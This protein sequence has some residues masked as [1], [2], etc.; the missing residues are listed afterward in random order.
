MLGGFPGHEHS[1]PAGPQVCLRCG[2][3]L[4]DLLS[5]RESALLVEVANWLEREAATKLEIARTPNQNDAYSQAVVLQ[6][7]TLMG[8][9]A[10]LRSGAWKGGKG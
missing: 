5:E 10:D 6:H 9:A 1:H 2:K 4:D 7:N 8:V 3:T